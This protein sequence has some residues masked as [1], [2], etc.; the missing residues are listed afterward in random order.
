MFLTSNLSQYQQLEE[1]PTIFFSKIWS[2]FSN[3]K[4][5]QNYLRFR[6]RTHATIC[7]VLLCCSPEKAAYPSMLLLLGI[8]LLLS[9]LLPWACSSPGHAAPPGHDSV[10]P[11]L[12][13]PLR[14][15]LPPPGHAAPP[16]HDATSPRGMLLPLRMMLPPPGHAAPPAHDATSPG[17]CCSPCA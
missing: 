11:G 2:C 17:A 3:S 5:K 1:L 12:M 15:M 8:L 7:R 9:M 16:A 14:M 6:G 4:P 13:I 10:S